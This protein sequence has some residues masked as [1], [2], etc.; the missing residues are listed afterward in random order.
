MRRFTRSHLVSPWQTSERWRKRYSALAR[1]N[2]GYVLRGY[3][4]VYLKACSQIWQSNV[5]NVHIE[6]INNDSGVNE[7]D[8]YTFLFSSY[9]HVLTVQH[10]YG[11]V[12]HGSNAYIPPNA[13]R[14]RQLLQRQHQP[15]SAGAP[16]INSPPPK[17]DIPKGSVNNPD[18]TVEVPS[19]TEL[20]SPAPLT[21]SV[22][23]ACS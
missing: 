8:K 15:S 6:E 4:A 12:V 11:V 9:L 17:A 19:T 14:Q 2:L 1:K 23:E 3:F 16:A 13:C 18:G 22:S 10:S 5:N 20:V 21:S 7:E